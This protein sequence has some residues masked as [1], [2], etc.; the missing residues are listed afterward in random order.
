MQQKIILHRFIINLLTGIFTIFV[1]TK[2][3]VSLIWLCLQS[4]QLPQWN[5]FIVTPLLSITC[6][7]ERCIPFF[8][9]S[10]D[11]LYFSPFM[12]LTLPS[13][14]P[15]AG[16]SSLRLTNYHPLQGLHSLGHCSSVGLL[17]DAVAPT[18]HTLPAGASCQS[19]C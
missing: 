6:I 5:H 11:F 16:A 12:F 18:W 15:A 10:A 7:Y 4:F 3:N 1:N 14:H 13:C 2:Q 19:P 8:A 17:D 9:S